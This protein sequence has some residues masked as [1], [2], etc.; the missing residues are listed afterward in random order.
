MCYSYRDAEIYLTEWQKLRASSINVLPYDL[1]LNLRS[2]WF[3]PEIR[4]NMRMKPPIS[5]MWI[6]KA[7]DDVYVILCLHLVARKAR[8][9]RNANC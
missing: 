4:D 9:T 8:K 2:V 7:S 5:C 6:P 3:G 1:S